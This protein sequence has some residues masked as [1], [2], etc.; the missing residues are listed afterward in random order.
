MLQSIEFIKLLSLIGIP[1][2]FAMVCALGGMLKRQG[3]KIK[4][5]MDAQQAQMRRDLI[6]DYYKWE[7]S[8]TIPERDL[9]SWVAQY[10]AYHH[11]AVLQGAVLRLHWRD[12]PFFLRSAFSVDKDTVRSPAS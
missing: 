5:L 7:K 10:N 11:A 9:T 6:E 8:E 1:S 12:G 3:D 4:I 2:I